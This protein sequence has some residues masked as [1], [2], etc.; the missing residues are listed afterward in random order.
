MTDEKK[1]TSPDDEYQFPKDEYVSL[2]E[3]KL[4]EEAAS[5]ETQKISFIEKVLGQLRET[6]LLKNKR[7]LIVIV[8]AVILG[9]VFHFVNSSQ[10]VTTLP[11]IAQQP[12]APQVAAPPQPVEQQP[13]MGSLDSL[14]DRSSHTESQLRDLQSQVSTLQ[15]TLNQAQE[16]NQQLQKS[17]AALTEQVQ[18]LSTRL[19]ELAAVKSPS[20][21]KRIVFHLRAILPDRAWITGSNGQTLTITA[22]DDVPQYGT[23][24]LIDAAE[25]V[26]TT[27]S[28]RKIE[29]G[30]NDY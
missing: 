22:G 19:S 6:P 10:K 9:I 28:G 4:D 1:N 15:N 25:G 20:N 7:I 16:S 2:D 24:Q 18:A 5:A 26:V 27:S 13:S 3:P 11:S 17:V 29:Y 30:S 14:Q 23:V 21:A 12:A 8:A